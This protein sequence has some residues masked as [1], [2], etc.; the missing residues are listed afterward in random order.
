[1]LKQGKGEVQLLWPKCPSERE[2]RKLV[3]LWVFDGLQSLP[4]LVACSH[5]W[6]DLRLPKT[7][8][9]QGG[10]QSSCPSQLLWRTGVGLQKGN[11]LLLVPHSRSGQ[12]AATSSLLCPRDSASCG[13]LSSVAARREG[14]ASGIGVVKNSRFMLSS[15]NGRGRLLE[16]N[17]YLMLN[18]CVHWMQRGPEPLA[19]PRALGQLWGQST[20]D[21]SL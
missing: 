18:F 20:P 4:P 6:T 9:R 7:L 13:L 11:F 16:G 1:M 8:F 12:W 10:A 15:E 5:C 21:M 3:Y 17:C 2:K 19:A 14:A